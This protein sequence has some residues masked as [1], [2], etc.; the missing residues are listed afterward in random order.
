MALDRKAM[1]RLL[2]LCWPPVLL[3]SMA[4]GQTW[5]R[6]TPRLKWERHP[7]DAVEAN[8]LLSH[9]CMTGV[10]ST[11]AGGG[12]G[13]QCANPPATREP[14]GTTVP[15]RRFN[16]S[17]L[18]PPK[19]VAGPEQVWFKWVSTVIYGHFLG[20]SSDDAA[21]A[22]WDGETHPEFWGGTLLLTKR[23]GEWQP[24]WYKHAIITR[25]CQR[26]KASTGRDVLLCEEEDGGMGHSYHILYIVDFTA[27][28][29]PW[30][31]A[32]LKSDSY[33][34]MCREEQVQSID[35]ITFHRDQGAS[36]FI[37]VLA[38]HGRRNL[39]EREVEACAEHRLRSSPATQNYR[40]GFVLRES[41]IPTPQSAE[42]AA[43]FAV[44]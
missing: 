25:Y 33:L 11:T 2:R 7:L 28:K 23:N 21:L 20:P 40:I 35:R 43:L 14:S 41:L 17:E 4:V 38:Q 29:S 13:F 6:E 1:I 32:V 42:A 36:P 12:K 27:P 8:A 44:R 9:V 34:L 26:V 37:T 18:V 31:A 22:G 30:D 5:N 3:A 15:A 16:P 10:E 24:V 19:G 39:S